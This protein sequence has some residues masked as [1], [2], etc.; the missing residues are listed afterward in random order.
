MSATT[1]L[2]RTLQEGIN[3]T[4]NWQSKY[5]NLS[6]AFLIPAEDLIACF[7]EMGVKMGPDGKLQL[8]ASGEFEPC[9]RAYL[10]IEDGSSEEA[11][12][13]VGTTTVDGVQYDDIIGTD[14]EDGAINGSGIYDFTKPCP[15]SCLRMVLRWS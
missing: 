8:D 9:V 12:L 3:W 11:L 2:T 4:K 14:G 1:P 5:P 10:A 15:K 6:K 7:N 13:I